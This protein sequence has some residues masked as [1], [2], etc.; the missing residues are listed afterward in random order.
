MHD[1]LSAKQISQLDNDELQ[2]VLPPECVLPE[3]LAAIAPRRIPD[4]LYRSKRIRVPFVTSWVLIVI[5]VASVAAGARPFGPPWSQIAFWSTAILGLLGV[6]GI[7]TSR[8]ELRYVQDGAVGAGHILN[9]SLVPAAEYNGQT[10]ALKHVVS[11]ALELSDGSVAVREFTGLQIQADTGRQASIRTGDLLPIVWLPGRFEKTAQPY[12]FLTFNQEKVLTRATGKATGAWQKI[13][14]GLAVVGLFAVL[15]GNMLLLMWCVPVSMNVP[16]VVT[17]GVVGALLLGGAM[18][19]GIVWE[20]KREDRRAAERNLQAVREGY[21]VQ[22]GNSHAI[23]TNT[24]K[25]W[26]YRILVGAG[27]LL[28]GG[29]TLVM[30]AFGANRFLDRSP[31][32]EREIEIL[33]VK[34]VGGNSPRTKV[35]FR[36]VDEPQAEYSKE[37]VPRDLPEI[38]LF[39]GG[40][41]SAEWHPGAFGWPWIG[42]VRAAQKN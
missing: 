25:G 16:V 30:W 26:L 24:P 29:L 22:Q 33:G 12:A 23:L 15:I 21:A 3:E 13:G 19:F 35:A 7:F 34:E 27:S 9:L 5:F 6:V 20:L 42:E 14:M 37:Y 1:E 10:I 28:L 41:A 17:I 4:E 36:P 8:R 31:P 18:Y 40:R 32:V 11:L 39:A 2:I 38:P